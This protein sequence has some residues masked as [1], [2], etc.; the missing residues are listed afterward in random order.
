MRETSGSE[1]PTHNTDQMDPQLPQLHTDKGS[2]ETQTRRRRLAKRGGRN[3]EEA[4]G[5]QKDL[6]E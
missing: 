3:G 1:L 5:G 6:T 2:D 4:A